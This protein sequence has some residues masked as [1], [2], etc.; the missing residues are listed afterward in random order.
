MFVDN[1]R[2]KSFLLDSGMAKAD[3]I[4]Q[5]MEESQRTGKRLGDLLV[6]KKI[7]D[8][9]QIRQ[10]Y[11]YIL[12]IPFVNL[13]KEPI[14]KEVLQIIPEPIAKKYKIVAFKKTNLELK[15][16]MLN[17]EDIQTIDFIRKKTGLKISP[18]ITTEDGI[19]NA[20]KQYEQSL[21]A[22]FGD[23]IEKNS[24]VIS[25]KGDLEKAAQDLPVIRIVDT[26]LKHAILQE[27][28]DIH[29]EPDEKEVRV[30]YR[31]DGI[32]HDAMSLPKAIIDGIVARIKILANL[33][34]DEHRMPQDGRFK[35]DQDGHRVAF[36]VSILPVYSGE[37]VV[38]RLLDESSKG[39][40][41]EAMGLW[42]SPLEKIHQA[43]KR[44]NGMILVTGPTGSG[45][46]TMLKWLTANLKNGY[47]SLYISKMPQKAE[48]FV[49]IFNEKFKKSWI[50]R[51]F[52]PHIKNLYQIPNF[53]NKKLGKKHLIVLCDEIHEADQEVLEWLR[54]LTDQVDNMSLIV[55]GLPVFEANLKENLE[56]FRKRITTKVELLSLTKEETEELIKK[57]I[58]SVGGNN[59]TPFT[60]ASLSIIYERTGGFPREV[61]RMCD[62]MVNK[63]VNKRVYSITP[64]LAETSPDITAI[65]TSSMHFI[66]SMTSLQKNII[67]L[68]AIKPRSPGEIANLIDLSKYK[69]RQHAVRSVFIERERTGRA[70]LYVLSPR[71]KTLVVKA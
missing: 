35:I 42:G 13:E 64:D 38:M 37:K 12:G 47:E 66:D 71:I 49:D 65:T 24:G 70:F 41:L 60:S 48:N 69:T 6:E 30:R 62:D 8:S 26:L 57:R 1:E 33:K 15:V 50:L 63:A 5:E 29:I 21:K 34:L 18:C 52:N 23:I 39:L 55:S 61:L 31:I 4:D 68:L 46:T 28:S 11:S 43:I 9:N 45:K 58:E 56:T 44:P 36:R 16:A 27:A 20:L 59:S 54:V 17:P 2:L 25:G 67:E 7:L 19:T 22:E 51:W 53:L 3:V 40:T 14:P 10:L 32:L